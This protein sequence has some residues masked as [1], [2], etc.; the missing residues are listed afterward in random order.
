MIEVRILS[1]VPNLNMMNT[2]INMTFEQAMTWVDRAIEQGQKDVA[3]SILKDLL[4]QAT[5][6]AEDYK[7]LYLDSYKD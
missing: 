5:K 3:I 1:L 2:K 4:N 7:Q 6:A